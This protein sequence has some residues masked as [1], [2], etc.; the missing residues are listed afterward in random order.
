MGSRIAEESDLEQG[1]AWIRD[2]YNKK[3]QKYL[4][5]FEKWRLRRIEKK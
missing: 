4:Q 2:V 3:E 1:F 5:S